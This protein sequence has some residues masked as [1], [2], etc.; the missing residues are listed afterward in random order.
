MEVYA[1]RTL[2]QDSVALSA[3]F[4]HIMIEGPSWSWSYYSLI[5]NYLYNQCL[6]PLKLWVRIPLWRG[7]L[8]ATLCCKVRQW[9]VTGYCFSPVTL[10]SSTNKTDRQDITEILLKV[11]FITIIPNQANH[12]HRNV[13]LVSTTLI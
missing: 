10:V 11:T 1:Y 5:Y 9:L 7:V 12:Y 3:S 2:H 8:Y 13:P 6:S 4:Y